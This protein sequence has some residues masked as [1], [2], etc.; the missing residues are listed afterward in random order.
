MNPD[1]TE[2]EITEALETGNTQ[3]FA[4]EILDMRHSQAKD[5]LSYIEQ[6]HRDI[7]KLEQSIQELHQLFVDMALLVE[8]QGELID[9]IE[10]NVNQS[11]AYTGEAVKQLQQAVQ[12]QRKSRKVSSISVTGCSD[13]TLENVHSDCNFRD[14][15]ICYRRWSSAWRAAGRVTE[16]PLHVQK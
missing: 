9:Q 8:T 6:R 14:C 16:Y 1:A 3:I 2:E 15:L 4:Q 5:A 13:L 10:Y 12:L 7:K 11:V